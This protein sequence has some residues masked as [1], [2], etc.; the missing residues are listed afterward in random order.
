[1]IDGSAGFLY[2][3]PILKMEDLNMKKMA[4]IILSFVLVISVAFGSAPA[5]GTTAG[6]TKVPDKWGQ[7]KAEVAQLLGSEGHLITPEEAYDA[8]VGIN[9]L[10]AVDY[11]N[12]IRQISKFKNPNVI[13]LYLN[14]QLVGRFYEIY[15]DSG[16]E[17]FQ[18][19]CDALSILYGSSDE[20]EDALPDLLFTFLT[21]SASNRDAEI[22]GTS[23]LI[24]TDVRFR[25]WMIDENTSVTLYGASHF[26][27]DGIYVIHLLYAHPVKTAYDFYG[28]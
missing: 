15:I 8:Y 16:E 12:T 27:S 6:A 4:G 14:D 20:S 23:D 9:G 13:F 10:E 11:S 1:M 28:L 3:D 19:L 24:P 26:D 21:G 2:N 25:T 5:E 7:S 17:D 22:E 18:Y